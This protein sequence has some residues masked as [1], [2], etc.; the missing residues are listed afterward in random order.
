MPDLKS[1]IEKYYDTVVGYRR[2]IHQHPELSHQESATAAFI[3]RT[4]R[5]MGLTPRTG[6]GGNGVIAVIEGAKGPG[7][8]V[9]LRA[10]FDALPIAEQTGLPFASQNEGVSHSCGHDMHTAMLLG[11]A[12]LLCDLRAC[13]CGSVKLVFQPAEED[14]L[15]CGAAP[16]IADGALENPHVDAMIGQH[17]WP[18][19]EVGSAAIRNGAMMASSDRFHLTVHGKS[20]HGSAPEDGV[21][22]IVIAAQIVT[23]LQTIVS[24]QVSPRDA[25]VVSL[26]T[27]H[28]GDRY[29][30]IANQVKLEGTCR[31]LS[32]A[33]RDKMP[34]RI[35]AIAKGV[36]ASMGGSCE[37]EYFRGY[38]PTVNDPAMFALVHDVMQQVVGDKAMVP[39]MS[40]L[41]GEDF[42]FYCEK[43]PCAFFWLGV[44]TPG[45]PFYPIHNGGFSPDEQAMKV[46][47]E[48]AVQSA[49]AFLNGEK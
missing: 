10:D 14:V 8:C 11:A 49:L 45:A 6:V 39:E 25:A 31:N 19:Y 42:S 26:G 15:N 27:I 36:A 34:A 40:A 23:A 28:G 16:M 17:V 46:G 9:G 22:A 2:H 38:S 33:V 20:S 41:G 30:V 35:E 21:D 32:P 1:Y 24:R 48:I 29:N 4:L 44:Q 5:G 18:Q 43:I 3:D 12:H 13:F 47:M 7:R 37:V